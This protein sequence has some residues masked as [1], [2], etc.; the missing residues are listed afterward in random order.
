[1]FRVFQIALR[2]GFYNLKTVAL[3]G[4][5]LTFGGG[6]KLGGGGV[7]WVGEVF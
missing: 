7:Y 1:M 3:V 2:G 6:L 4:E 5:G